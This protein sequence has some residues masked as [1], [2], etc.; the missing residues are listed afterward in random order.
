MRMNLPSHVFLATPKTILDIP[1]GF[2][3][4]DSATMLKRRRVE[5]DHP[6]HVQKRCR[7]QY[8]YDFSLLS[9]EL[10]LKVL[11]YLPISDLAICQ[12]CASRLVV[13]II[14][15]ICQNLQSSPTTRG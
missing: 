1:S 8:G 10:I 12:R 3:L 4:V 14:M 15:L 6:G 9:D 2:N 5:D 7:L 13:L 11:T